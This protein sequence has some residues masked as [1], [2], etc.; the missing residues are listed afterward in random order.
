MAVDDVEAQVIYLS[1]LAESSE[2]IR[3]LLAPG[4]KIDRDPKEVVEF[5][6]V[7]LGL[8]MHV[9]YQDAREFALVSQLVCQ[10]L[11]DNPEPSKDMIEYILTRR[12]AKVL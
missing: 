3:N 2:L 10:V 4:D 12:G 1:D 8:A 9:A 6:A 11:R 5:L 7:A